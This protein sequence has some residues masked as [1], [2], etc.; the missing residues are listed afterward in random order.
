MLF[1]TATQIAFAQSDQT[2]KADVIKVI[3][4]S[5]FKDQMDGIKEQILPQV[6]KDKVVALGFELDAIIA[7]FYDGLAIHAM[8]EFTKEDIKAILSF[9]E[10]PAGKK[11]TKKTKEISENAELMMSL[12]N[13][14]QAAV[15]KVMK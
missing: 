6:P 1:Y 15:T 14:I 8:K 2:F 12:Q 3:E 9:Y 13:E 4:K 10:S 7:K 5:G 11:L